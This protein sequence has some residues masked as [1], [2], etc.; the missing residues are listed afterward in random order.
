MLSLL[1]KNILLFL[2][3]ALL[4]LIYLGKGGNFA[5]LLVLLFLL[6][7]FIIRDWSPIYLVYGSIVCLFFIPF[8]P[9]LNPPAYLGDPM[10]VNILARYAFYLIIMYAIISIIKWRKMNNKSLIK[11][12][13][14]A[15]L[16]FLSIGVLFNYEYWSP[17]TV[18]I[19]ALDKNT[20][21]S[22]SSKDFKNSI[23]KISIR[24]SQNYQETANAHDNKHYVSF[25]FK[26]KQKISPH[27]NNLSCLSLDVSDRINRIRGVGFDFT[28]L[29][30]VGFLENGNAL[31]DQE[32]KNKFIWKLIEINGS[33]TRELT[34]TEI[35]DVNKFKSFRLNQYWP[36]RKELLYCF[37]PQFE[38]KEE[39][40]LIIPLEITL[41]R[42][43]REY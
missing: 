37:A 32:Q 43:I 10:G 23:G 14:I 26:I 17:A 5:D 11:M 30:D 28:I 42:E 8:F 35:L 22:L 6:L 27:K 36:Q 39:K 31:F 21:I 16:I 13:L 25:K 24:R 2:Y 41:G 18:G 20:L 4:I 1:K 29:P 9:N 19:K 12:P 15:I 3:F 7:A 34:G 40:E 38:I 33:K